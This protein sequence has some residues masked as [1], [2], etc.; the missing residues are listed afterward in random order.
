MAPGDA[1]Y[2]YTYGVALNSSG[3]ARHAIDVLR[4]AQHRHPS[5]REIL[6]ALITIERD[7]GHVQASAVWARKLEQLNRR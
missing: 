7:R 6:N 2:A 4:V 3:D 1:R 5:D